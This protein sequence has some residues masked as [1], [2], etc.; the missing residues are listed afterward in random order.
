MFQG[1]N[2]CL[3]YN[4]TTIGE[5]EMKRGD[6]GIHGKGVRV[7]ECEMFTVAG[8]HKEMRNRV[9]KTTESRKS[10]AAVK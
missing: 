7:E 8:L 6:W 2:I 10:I 9:G 4:I 5:G 1:N 3:S